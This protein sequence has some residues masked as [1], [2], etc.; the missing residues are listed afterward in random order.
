LSVLDNDTPC[1]IGS[2]AASSTLS[3]LHKKKLHKNQNAARA[4]LFV[5]NTLTGNEVDQSQNVARATAGILV[6]ASL[7]V[8][9]K[10]ILH[11]FV[12]LHSVSF[13]NNPPTAFQWL[14]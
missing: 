3:Q 11:W 6:T 5:G 8:L 1:I 10:N 7:P 13:K 14:K 9:D 4:S 2:F 12:T